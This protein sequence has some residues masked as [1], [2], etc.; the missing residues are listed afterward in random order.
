M[1]TQS[2]AE[3]L[4]AVVVDSLDES[5]DSDVLARR[6]ARSRTQFFRVFRALIEE[7][8]SAMRR[9]L[10]LERAAF[11]LGR[12]ALPVTE[13]AFD[14]GY[15]SLEAFTRAFHRAFRISPSLYRRMRATHFHLPAP[16]TVHFCAA[17]RSEGD[18]M[19]LFDLF[20]GADSFHI[21][22]LLEHS[23]ALSDAQLDAPLGNP[24][25]VFPWPTPAM[26][27]RDLLKRLVQTK[28]IWTAALAGGTLPEPDAERPA[29]GTPDALLQRLEKT[30]REFT[31]I[32]TD[33][34]NRNAWSDTFVDALCEPPET[35][36]F[37]GMFTHVITF[38]TYLRLLALDELRRLGVKVEGFGCPTEYEAS[39]AKAPVTRA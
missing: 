8:P 29:E 17:S 36:S 35:F 12:T 15:G 18:T 31:R 20:A 25:H 26:S 1:S 14:A 19:D 6:A 23:R 4:A 33:V 30:D 16:T 5:G 24:A 7:T 38:N 11:Q 28:E 3:R 10:R 9:R 13:I 2:D 27:L 21:R 22:K 39:V 34:R 32:L 37:G